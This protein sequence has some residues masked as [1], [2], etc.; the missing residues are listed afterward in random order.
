MLSTRYAIPTIVI[1]VLAL[2]PTVLHSYI[3]VT[4]DGGKSVNKIPTTLN[5]F[6]STPARRN[7]QWGMDIFG[8]EDWLERIYQNRQGDTIRLFVARSYDQKR[9]YHHPELALSYGQNFT[10]KSVTTLPD[11]PEIPVHLLEKD[12]NSMLVA[13]VLLHDNKFIED[14]IRHQFSDSLKLL[15]SARKPMT[16]FY[17]AQSGRPSEGEVPFS[18]SATAALLSLAIKS[19]QSQT[20]TMHEVNAE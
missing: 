7:S 5:N 14:P 19:F 9:L 8:S 6:T 16:L 17:V 3:G 11:Y 13:Y 1:L 15:L 20:E 4:I 10:K 12:D 18:Q 2:I